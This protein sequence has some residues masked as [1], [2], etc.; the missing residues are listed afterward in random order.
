MRS[1]IQR[2]DGSASTTK[3]PSITSSPEREVQRSA[4][5]GLTFD[6]AVQRLAPVQQKEDTASVHA[7]AQRGTSGGGGGL[8]YGSQI[9]R[10]FG[11]HDVSGISAHVGGKASEAC[12]SM[13]AEAYAS[14]NSVAFKGNP[15]LHTAAHEAAHI[16]QQ[17]SGVQLSGGV[18]QVGDSYEQ[19]ADAVADRVVQGKSAEDLLG[20]RSSGGAGGVQQS[21]Q[22]QAKGFLD[23]L[24]AWFTEV[25]L[26]PEKQ[27]VAEILLRK[28]GVDVS[29][30]DNA[31][32]ARYCTDANQGGKKTPDQI[33]G[34]IAPS[35]RDI[36]GEKKPTQK[37]ESTSASPVQ[38]NEAEP[39]QQTRGAGAGVQ[40]NKIGGRPDVSDPTI[41][42]GITAAVIM[43]FNE[44]ASADETIVE[45]TKLAIEHPAG[46]FL[47]LPVGLND[48]GD[49][50]IKQL[51]AAATPYNVMTGAGK[52]VEGKVL[53]KF[54][55]K[56][57]ADL[58]K[59]ID[60]VYSAVAVR[61]NQKTRQQKGLK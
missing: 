37:K 5:R 8:P 40:M 14:G 31:T 18:G 11:S 3:S 25:K 54:K 26:S 36:L 50:Q 34:D 2:K 28:H 46:V 22:V 23:N 27:K 42:G 47:G 39:V 53:E 44:G 35:L 51:F 41:Q 1:S 24:K 21:R 58:Q 15:D 30:M 32:F 29:G 56:K 19:H 10:A 49:A 45:L 12:D 13:G 52:V 16:V 4:L 43:A 38:R 17:R 61:V 55:V 59:G 7:A 9:Q 48:L 20:G 6:E 33:A 57:A 60:I